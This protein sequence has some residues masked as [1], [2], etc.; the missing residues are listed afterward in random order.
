M[1][2]G[3]LRAKADMA[4]EGHVQR[5]GQAT[6]FCGKRVALAD[7]NPNAGTTVDLPHLPHPPGKA[8]AHSAAPGTT[9][10]NR[11]VAV[12]YIRQYLS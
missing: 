1:A 2:A 3:Y 8:S 6:A 4:R 10:V 7:G 5:V 11:Q 9:P 12:I